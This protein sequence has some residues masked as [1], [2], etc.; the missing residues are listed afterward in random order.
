VI[1]PCAQ[2]GVARRRQPERAQET[3][4]GGTAEGTHNEIDAME[5]VLC[6][7]SGRGGAG[8]SSPPVPLISRNSRRRVRPG[9]RV[10]LKLD[11]PP[12]FTAV[13]R[14]TY[15]VSGLTVLS[16]NVTLPVL[17]L[18]AGVRREA[19]PRSARCR[20]VP[21]TV[22]PESE[23]VRR[24]DLRKPRDPAGSGGQDE[25]RRS[26]CRR[27]TLFTVPPG[28]P[29]PRGDCF[30]SWIVVLVAPFVEYLAGDRP[31]LRR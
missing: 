5:D 28:T 7:R 17:V 27:I 21:G 30:V 31:L 11:E 6:R 20:A 1:E 4:T 3:S 2:L 15:V 26:G 19:L 12:P 24:Q 13:T 23:T 18:A 9:C 16:T 22:D 29:T 14:Y 10:V 8:R 25:E